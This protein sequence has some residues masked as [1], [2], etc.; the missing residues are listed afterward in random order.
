MFLTLMVGL[1]IPFF[2]LYVT[3]LAVLLFRLLR[4]AVR[5]APGAVIPPIALLIPLAGS[6]L[7]LMVMDLLMMSYVAWFFHVLLGLIPTRREAAAVVES[8]SIV[9]RASV[10]RLYQSLSE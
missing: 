6:L 3:A 9:S 2:I 10:A 8:P 4:V 1:G 7:H 5:P